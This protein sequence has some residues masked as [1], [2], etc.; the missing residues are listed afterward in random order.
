M[1]DARHRD[2]TVQELHVKLAEK[3]AFVLLDVR[4]PA[5]LELARIDDAR[6]ERVPLSQLAVLGTAALPASAGKKDAE[7]L[8]LCHHGNRSAQVAQWLT[9]QGWTQVSNVVG[10]IDAYARRIDAAVGLY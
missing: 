9:L 4:E 2:I 10:G 5:E 8:V 6:L 1:P 7:I 3:D